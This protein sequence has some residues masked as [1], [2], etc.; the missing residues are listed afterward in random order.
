MI[1]FTKV[2]SF[3]PET[4]RGDLFSYIY[5]SPLWNPVWFTERIKGYSND[6]DDDDDDPA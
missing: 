4:V 5:I 2:K 3:E 6:D 1:N